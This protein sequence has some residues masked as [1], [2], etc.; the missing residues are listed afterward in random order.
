V[1][2]LAF[3]RVKFSDCLLF[4]VLE[5]CLMR[6]DGELMT[7]TRHD[8]DKDMFHAACLGLGALGIIVSL[9]LQ[10]E[11]AFRLQQVQY[12]VSLKD[13]RASYF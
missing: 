4:E 10:C 3:L 8:D 12:G 2:I 7:L 13:V 5:L 1:Y 6:S 9:K 11:P